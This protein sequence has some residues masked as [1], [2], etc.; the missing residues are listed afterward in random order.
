MKSNSYLSPCIKINTKWIKD[1]N[2]IPEILPL[3]E[4]N[5]RDAFQTTGAGKNFL[6]KIPTAQE[7]TSSINRWDYM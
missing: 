4:E 6:N 1:F 3:L 7:P 5:V 2:L